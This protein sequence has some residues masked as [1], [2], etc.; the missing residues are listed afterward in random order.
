MER[1]E[2]ILV[3]LYSPGTTSEFNE[4]INSSL[5]LMKILFMLGQ[6]KEDLPNFYDAWEKY[7]YGPCDFSVYDDLSELKNE[8]LIE[9]KEQ[10]FKNFTIFNLTLIGSQKAKN[11]FDFLDSPTKDTIKEVKKEANSRLSLTRLLQY[12]YGKYPGWDTQSIFNF[13]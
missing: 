6:E 7:L 10:P 8:G 5:R 1:K 11:I 12:V 3:S 4:P 13:K 2:W 9:E